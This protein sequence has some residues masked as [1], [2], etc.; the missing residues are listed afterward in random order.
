MDALGHNTICIKIV[1]SFLSLA[2]K[3]NRKANKAFLVKCMLDFEKESKKS[4]PKRL[5]LHF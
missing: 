5:Y 3:D 4:S 1:H 2:D